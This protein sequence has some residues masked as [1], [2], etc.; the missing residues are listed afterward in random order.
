MK[1]IE[2]IHAKEAISTRMAFSPPKRKEIVSRPS[3]S[4]VQL[5]SSVIRNAQR[6]NSVAEP[7]RAKASQIIV[8]CARMDLHLGIR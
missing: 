5:K 4:M 2:Q 3:F 6:R 1:Q 8:S 7:I